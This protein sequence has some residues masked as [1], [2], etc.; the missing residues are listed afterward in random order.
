MKLLNFFSIFLVLLF[1][2]SSQAPVQAADNFTTDYN[3]EYQVTDG[4]TTH[5]LLTVTLTNSSTQYYASS[6]KVHLGFQD[7]SNVRASDHEGPISPQVSK[8]EDGYIIDVNFNKKA[9]GKGTK[10][11]FR[12]A[13]DTPT[14]AHKYGSV[15]EINIPGIANPEDFTTFTV[16]VKTPPSFGSPKYVKP[17]QPNNKSLTFTK[18]QLGKSG[19]SVAFGEKQQHA[20]HLVY[21][22][23]NSSLLPSKKEITLPPTTNYQ[24]ILLTGINPAPENVYK[25]L[26]GNWIARYTLKSYQEID[27]AVDGIA[28]LHLTP[29]QVVLSP[30]DRAEYI[31]PEPF[32]ETE[33]PQIQQL[34]KELKTPEAIYAYVVKTLTYDFKRVTE[35]RGRLGAAG[36]LKKP[37]SAVCREFTDLFIAIAR[38]A[39][40]PARELDG[41]AYT[42][43]TKQRPLSFEKD[44]LHSWP[45]YYD[46]KKKTWV[47]VDP[48]WG[49]T[50]GGVDYFST[51]D[52]D[53]FVFAIHGRESSLPVP[54]GGYKFN[55]DKDRK[56]ITVTFAESSLEP[57]PEAAMEMDIL[58]ELVAGLPLRGKLIIRNNGAAEIPSQ[59]LYVSSSFFSPKEQLIKTAGIPPFGY[60]TVDI[61]F[62]A[63]PVLTNTTG[64][65]T[66]RLADQKLE[67]SVK[68]SPVYMNPWGIGGI[69]GGIFTIF[70]LIFA[71]RGRSLSIQRRKG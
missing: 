9:V 34:A 36:V 30:E 10:L 29:K 40:I 12:I 51:L 54:A 3:V 39:G 53:H 44:I 58:P 19:I 31:A 47:M 49:N 5:A 20:F 46:E 18:E 70:I 56:D 26:D 24:D 13:F 50:T 14:I 41:F 11:V 55:S 62:D 23:K 35:G 52:Y 60:F 67:K 61:N 15:W 71:F 45:E 27:V 65:F 33:D 69:L 4:G 66:I 22:L 32:W 42:E 8:T 7:I 68:V 63:P 57:K 17:A 59:I 6:Y 38:A 25:D 1:F 43:N 2:I 16:T 64:N 21:H 37:D 48:T 28:N